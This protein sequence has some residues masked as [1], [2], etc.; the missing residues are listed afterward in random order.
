MLDLVVLDSMVQL[1]FRGVL[2]S[3]LLFCVLDH[4]EAFRDA[5]QLVLQH[6]HAFKV[7]LEHE[8]KGC[9][10]Q[11]CYTRPF[12]MIAVRLNDRNTP[13]KGG[14]AIGKIGVI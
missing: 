7:D 14:L 9:H 3:G 13:K 12:T 6:D 8:E 5:I 4:H 1:A 10:L 11:L 2:V